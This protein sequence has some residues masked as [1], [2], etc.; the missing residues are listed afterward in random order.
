M[1]TGPNV[2]DEPL[3][4]HTWLNRAPRR[5]PRRR[6]LRMSEPKVPPTSAGFPRIRGY[7]IDRELGRGAMGVV[8]LAHLASMNRTVAV[9]I[10]AA[11][12]ADEESIAR[13]ER[14]VETAI[15]GANIIP[16]LARGKID[17]THYI[18]KA[19][20]PGGSLAD[21]LNRRT[22]SPA[23]TVMVG[24]RIS[25]ALAAAHDDGVIHRDIKSSN[26]LLDSRGYAFWADFGVSRLRQSARLTST[27]ALV[28]T[29]KLVTWLPNC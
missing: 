1:S 13:F 2:S 15:T 17:R 18:D 14:E 12:L 10:L 4:S 20:L 9:K 27:S 22:L 24:R 3:L 5:P 23:D 6:I 28:G 25:E 21:V 8:Y 11:G 29:A 26:I 16:V 19:Y 7:R